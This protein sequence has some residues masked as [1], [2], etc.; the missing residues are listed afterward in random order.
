MIDVTADSDDGA[1]AAVNLIIDKLA[2]WRKRVSGLTYRHLY[3]AAWVW[4]LRR[5]L[6]SRSRV[7][8]RSACRSKLETMKRSTTS[9]LNAKNSRTAHPQ[10]SIIRFPVLA[11]QCC[12]P[13]RGQSLG[14]KEVRALLMPL[15]DRDW[16]QPHTRARL[17]NRLRGVKRRR[18]KSPSRYDAIFDQIN[19]SEH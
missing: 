7:R 3:P 4:V 12:I 6:L 11:R 18:D 10:A 1:A 16:F 9:R 5:P 14:F 8:L 17:V 19:E 15:P 2:A 13:H